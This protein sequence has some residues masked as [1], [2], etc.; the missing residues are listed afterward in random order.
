MKVGDVVWRCGSTLLCYISLFSDLVG[1][2]HIFFVHDN[3]THCEFRKTYAT[4]SFVGLSV[5][6]I[7]SNG[8]FDDIHQF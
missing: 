1:Q 6:G 8:Y 2:P 7:L 4:K 5:I 3:N